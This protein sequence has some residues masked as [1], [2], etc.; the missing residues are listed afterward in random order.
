MKKNFFILLFVITLLVTAVPSTALA[1]TK[2][3]NKHSAAVTKLANACEYYGWCI[4]GE[5]PGGNNKTTFEGVTLY[6]GETWGA[7]FK[8]KTQKNFVTKYY[9]LSGKKFK[10]YNFLNIENMLRKYST[11]K[12]RA[13][14]VKKKTLD[15]ADTLITIAQKY[16]WEIKNAYEGGTDKYVQ[17]IQFKN[18]K[19]N[20]T[21]KITT[22]RQK[23]NKRLVTSYYRDGIKS[24]KKAITEWLE[25]YHL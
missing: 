11:K 20:W 10:R 13:A 8:V 15:A 5:T 16:N 12:G 3:E 7:T 17:T 19:Y 18:E 23:T 21:A 14:T 1:G 9:V 24:S 25:K 6:K 2:L 22:S 4:Q